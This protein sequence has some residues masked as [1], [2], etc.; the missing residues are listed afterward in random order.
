VVCVAAVLG[1]YG[2]THADV[3]SSMTVQGRLT[4][5]GGTPL[6]AGPKTMSFQMHTASIGGTQVWPDAGGEQ[7]I[8]TSDDDGLWTAEIGT[9]FPLSSA[10]FADSARWLEITVDDGVNPVETL[11]RVRLVTSPFAFQAAQASSSRTADTAWHAGHATNADTADIALTSLPD[12]DW[13]V[14]D[15]IL[16]TADFRGIVRGG[17]GNSYSGD[18]AHTTINLGI[19]CTTSA[20]HSTIAGGL[21]NRATANSAVVAGGYNNVA[22]GL[23]S[24]VGGGTGHVASGIAGYIGGGSN[25]EATGVGASVG[26]GTLNHARGAWSTIAGGGGQLGADSNTAYG[27]Y[28][29]IAG[30]SGNHAFGD[31]SFA[32]GHKAQ[33]QHDGAFVWAGNGDFPFDTAF[34]SSATNSFTA[35]AT[36]GVVFFTSNLSAVYVTPGSGT[37]QSYC[38]R[39]AKTNFRPADG[40]QLLE[41]VAKLPIHQWNY[42]SQDSSVQHIGPTAQ[43]FYDLFQVGDSRL[44]I[45]TVDPDGIALAAIQELERRTRRIEQLESEVAELRRMIVEMRVSVSH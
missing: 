27:A 2:T 37:W 15:T 25:N 4:D 18:S 12:S 31:Y 43:D 42:K 26:G 32:G 35:W 28:A 10:V 13:L 33:A 9:S 16:F 5:A 17:A 36:G 14:T 21:A 24:V 6:P 19:A 1:M 30:G 8:V 7:H 44:T 22:S 38:D 20:Y 34:H 29:A 39:N 40:A 23:W 41:K 45:A 3:P 11:P